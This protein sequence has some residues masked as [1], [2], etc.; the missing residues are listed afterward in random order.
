[1]KALLEPKLREMQLPESMAS[2]PEFGAANPKH[3]H[4]E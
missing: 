4:A 2:E 1:M 3:P